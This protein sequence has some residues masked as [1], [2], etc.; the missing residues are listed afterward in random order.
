MEFLLS[1]LSLDSQENNYEEDFH[2]ST[3]DK[4]KRGQISGSGSEIEEEISS[5]GDDQTS[6]SGGV[7]VNLGLFIVKMLVWHC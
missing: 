7:S 4:T 6:V 1:F 5:A 2:S 3:S